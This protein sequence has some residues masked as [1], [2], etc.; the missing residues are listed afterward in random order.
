MVSGHVG[1]GIYI[2]GDNTA[3]DI[4]NSI[5]WGNGGGIFGTDKITAKCTIID[6][7]TEWN[8]E[9]VLVGDPCFGDGSYLGAASPCIDAGDCS[10]VEAGLEKRTTRADGSVDE[11]LVDLGYHPT[12]GV[13]V[14]VTRPSLFLLVLVGQE[15]ELRRPVAL[16]CHGHRQ[17]RR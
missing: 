8:G 6:E 10:A 1:Q 2:D 12:A 16:R 14:P 11:G 13:E 3:V 17:G 4:V 9:N 5:V 7:R 15:E